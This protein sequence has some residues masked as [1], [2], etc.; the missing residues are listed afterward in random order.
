MGHATSDDSYKKG[1]K[2]KYKTVK[3]NDE[4]TFALMESDCTLRFGFKAVMKSFFVHQ[5]VKFVF[6]KALRN[7][8]AG[9]LI[10]IRSFS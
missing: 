3:T 9:K 5:T 7:A 4:N 10:C 2:Q 8:L 6:S 1:T